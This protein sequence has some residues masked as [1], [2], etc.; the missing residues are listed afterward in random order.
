MKSIAFFNNKGGVGKTT[1]LCNIASALSFKNNKKVLIIDADPQ[2]NATTYCLESDIVENLYAKHNRETIEKFLNPIRKGTGY[3]SKNITP[4]KS[5]RFEVDIIPGDPR[6]SLSEDL[7]AADW[8][9]ASSGDPRGLQTTFVFKEMILRYTEYDI[10]LFDVGPSL[11]AINRSVLIACNYFIMPM[12]VD[13]FSLMAINNISLTLNKWKRGLSKGLADYEVEEFEKH[14]VRDIESKWDLQF[15][16]YVVQ[17]YTAKTVRGK[18]RPVKAY[19]KII[20]QIPSKILKEII[21]PYSNLPSTT[22]YN[23]GKIGNLH[24]LVPMSQTANSPIF[25]L[26]ASDGVV[27]AHFS[28]V[29]EAEDL[30]NDIATN[31]LVNI[32]E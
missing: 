19:E 2:C 7:I 21:E 1:L 25:R 16:G 13:I 29:N 11:G 18:K 4:I 28:K 15:A 27:G 32:G 12:S 22:Q 9:G 10:I 31:L 3:L 14:M 8:A 30:F 24:S 6:L 23:L 17:Q 5:P 20:K 26:K